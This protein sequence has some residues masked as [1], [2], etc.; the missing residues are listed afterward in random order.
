MPDYNSG[1]FHQGEDG[2]IF[3]NPDGSSN[4]SVTDY[5][6]WD[7]KQIKAA[8]YGMSSGVSTD[9]NLAH[10][11]SIAN[12]QS[13]LDAA[14]AFFHVQ[15]I[16]E[17]VTKSL[18]DQAKALAGDNGPWG[19]SAADSFLTMMTNFSRQVKANADVLSGVRRATT[20]SPINSPTTRSPSRAR[21]TNSRRS[22]SGT[23]TRP[24]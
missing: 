3:G 15:R 6:N 24:S 7:W 14:N 11:R 8:V 16:L 2:T 20:P 22:T 5:D 17:G 12:P 9:A 21:R 1:G 18:V 10:A 19:G 4:G 23:P 13:L